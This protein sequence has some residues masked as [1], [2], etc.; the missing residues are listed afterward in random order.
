[1]PAPQQGTRSPRPEAI[2]SPVPVSS[3]TGPPIFPP[4]NVQPNQVHS[5]NAVVLVVAA[6]SVFV[7]NLAAL[8]A[9]LA[10]LAVKNRQE[11]QQIFLKA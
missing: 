5:Q 3:S 9:T 8:A 6:S 11:M 1:M 4:P 10:P 7:D 2:F